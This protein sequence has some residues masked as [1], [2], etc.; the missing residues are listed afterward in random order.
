M[1]SIFLFRVKLQLVFIFHSI[2]NLARRA[3]P[4]WRLE[5]LSDDDDRGDHDL[6]HG[7]D[8]TNDPMS[9][10]VH[11]SN[12]VSVRWNFRRMVLAIY[13]WGDRNDYWYYWYERENYVSYRRL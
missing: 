11:R 5:A 7:P 4:T 8:P 6:F 12:F 1:L 13:S 10:S 9:D 2:A 3:C